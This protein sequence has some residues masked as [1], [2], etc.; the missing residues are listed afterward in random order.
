MAGEAKGILKTIPLS[1]IRENPDALRDVNKTTEDYIGLVDSVKSRGVLI[2]I[3]VREL[4]GENGQVVYGLV[5]GLQRYSAAMDAG[6]T[7]VHA[8][9]QDMENAEV[10]EAQLIANVHKIETK[11]VEYSKQLLKILSA[12]PIMRMADLA[13]KLNKSN[14]WLSERLG[15]LKLT[16]EIQ[17]MVNDQ[18]INLSNA[19]ALAKLPPEEQP[20]FLDRAMTQSPQEFVPTATQRVKEIK[21]AKR[22]GKTAA[23]AEFVPVP[24]ARR[25]SELKDE[26]ANPTIGPA[27][28]TKQGVKDGKGG[29]ALGVAWA[30][31]MDN[32]SIAAAKERDTA[33]KTELTEAKKKRDLE[34]AQARQKEATDKVAELTSGK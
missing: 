26:L 19:F 12:N 7:E 5:D 2:P 34:R 3:L 32:D 33:R 1:Q 18:K 22:Q 17:A 6:L 20:N 13:A 15:L 16:P 27:L 29:F 31:H 4:K 24:H 30:L 14:T 8:H 9:V 25:M 21:E 10:L 28:C 11:A 23:P